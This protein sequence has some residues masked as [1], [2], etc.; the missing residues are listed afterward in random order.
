MYETDTINLLRVKTG[1]SPKLT[2]IGRE[3]RLASVIVAS[4]VAILG[5][6]TSIGYII[7]RKNFNEH[8]TIKKQMESDIVS[9]TKT[10]GLYISVQDRIRAIDKIVASSYPWGE[11]LT[12]IVG[13]GDPDQLST[14]TLDE[15]ENVALRMD[16]ATFDDARGVIEK[17]ITH[18][19]EKV[20]TS[21][22]LAT[23]QLDQ[24][25]KIH[26]ALSFQ[27]RYKQ[28]P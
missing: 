2:A 22:K 23:F 24:D 15:S 1:F 20:I 18:M 25:G 26:M 19:Q 10:E 8:Q 16:T 27:L 5:M 9:Y 6:L 3:L 17:I 7:L 14:F 11:A 21:P 12:T 4:L 13:F 28:K